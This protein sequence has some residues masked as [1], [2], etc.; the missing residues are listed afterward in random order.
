MNDILVYLI[1]QQYHI[2]AIG[3]QVKDDPIKSKI[4]ANRK[5]I[6]S[7]EFFNA[8]QM[9][10]KPSFSI[11]ILKKEYNDEENVEIDGVEYSVYRTYA[12]DDTI[13]L[14]LTEKLGDLE[15]EVT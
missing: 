3:Q 13:E 9:G 4:Y 14:Y 15:W 6:G 11:K 10:L 7:N 1:K 12:Y 5:S 8:G 2:D